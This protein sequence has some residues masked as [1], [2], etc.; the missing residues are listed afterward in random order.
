VRAAAAVIADTTGLA[1]YPDRAQSYWNRRTGILAENDREDD[2]GEEVEVKIKIKIQEESGEESR[3]AQA[4]KGSG[5]EGRAEEGSC[6]E[7]GSE[8][9]KA[10]G[11]AEEV[12]SCPGT[13]DAGH[14]L[15]R[16]VEW[17][18]EQR[19]LTSGVI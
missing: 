5:K 18:R 11:S 6:E 2:H 12:C 13:S 14:G 9:G 10:Q 16:P 17:R 7:G 4:E 3:P 15:T 1:R 8:E 19:Q